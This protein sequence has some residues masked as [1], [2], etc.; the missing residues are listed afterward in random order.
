MSFTR[1]FI[2]KRIKNILCVSDKN[3]MK[4]TLFFKEK[5]TE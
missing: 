1:S 5:I 3:S 2:H 4:D